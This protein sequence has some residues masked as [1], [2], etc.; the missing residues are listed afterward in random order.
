LAVAPPG[1]DGHFFAKPLTADGA[2]Y[3]WLAH[4]RGANGGFPN[5][6]GTSLVAVSGRP[7]SNLMDSRTKGESTYFI[8]VV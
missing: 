8:T 2:S 3:V 7:N 5:P 6:G 4:R 1:C